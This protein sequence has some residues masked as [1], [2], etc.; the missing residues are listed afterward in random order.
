MSK[1]RQPSRKVAPTYQSS[2]RYRKLPDQASNVGLLVCRPSF[3]ARIIKGAIGE[4]ERATNGVVSTAF[5]IPKVFPLATLLDSYSRGC[6]VDT[7]NQSFVVD[8]VKKK[9]R[10]GLRM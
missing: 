5:K 1:V 2:V 7:D 10:R 4:V 3:A 8:S 9:K 6:G